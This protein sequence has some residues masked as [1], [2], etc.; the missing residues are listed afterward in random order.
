MKS[1]NV[2]EPSLHSYIHEG[3]GFSKMLC[4]KRR[5]VVNSISPQCLSESCIGKP[6]G[7]GSW[8]PRQRRPRKNIASHVSWRQWRRAGSC[9]CWWWE[10]RPN[11]IFWQTF[12]VD[13][14]NKTVGSRQPVAKGTWEN[15]HLKVLWTPF[16]TNDNI[17]LPVQ[18]AHHNVDVHYSYSTNFLICRIW[19]R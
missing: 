17:C 19:T 8:I 3:K 12:W 1:C 16:K 14:A 13:I 10:V 7:L 18:G 6:Y 5:S 2:C 9:Y 15:W 4:K 11:S